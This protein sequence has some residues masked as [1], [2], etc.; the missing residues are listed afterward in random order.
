M[1]LRTFIFWAVAVLIGV[2]LIRG[3]ADGVGWNPFN[4]VP[5]VQINK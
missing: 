1:K 5:N 4:S 3:M 2:A